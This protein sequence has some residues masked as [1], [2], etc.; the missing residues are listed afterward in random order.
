MTGLKI[1]EKNESGQ[2][3]D[4]YFHMNPVTHFL[5]GWL[6][7]NT[8]HLERRDRALVAVNRAVVEALRCRFT[9]QER[10]K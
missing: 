6:I 1:L 3:H 7:A 10:K 8:D 2:F 4:E 9:K 5:T